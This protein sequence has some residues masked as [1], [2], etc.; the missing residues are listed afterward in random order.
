MIPSECREDSTSVPAPESLV[1]AACAVLECID[2]VTG[3][4]S[5]RASAVTSA[6][7]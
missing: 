5:S 7:E 2:I 4:L 6:P 3:D 1:L